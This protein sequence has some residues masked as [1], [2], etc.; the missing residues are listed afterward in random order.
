LSNPTWGRNLRAGGGLVVSVDMT[1]NV[2]FATSGTGGLRT[3][4]GK[5]VGV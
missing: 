4:K 1:S 2:F 5:K 3:I